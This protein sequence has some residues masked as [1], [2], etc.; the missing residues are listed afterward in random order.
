MQK[1]GRIG[2][3]GRF[4][5]LHKGAQALLEAACGMADHV[6][7]GIGSSNKYNVRN[8]FTPAETKD[9]INAVL[10]PRFSNYEIVEVPDFAQRAGG[11]DG[12]MWRKYVKEHFKELDA[13]ISG[14]PWVKTL[15]EP[16]YKILHPQDIIE[17][18]IPIKATLVRERMAKD[19]DWKELLPKE[20]AE[21]IEQNNLEA[22]FKKEF[23]EETMARIKAGKDTT[24]PEKEE[25]EARHA[26]E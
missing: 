17:H 16:D 19:D 14:N 24:T 8:P 7:I 12:Q 10:K 18:K 4:K 23:G 5:P 13:F 20:V 15:L 9:M 25:D 1:L 21:Y 6:I 11:A 3:I 22:R 2:L 26:A